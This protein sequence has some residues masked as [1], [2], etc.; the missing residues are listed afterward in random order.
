MCVCED[1]PKVL[2]PDQNSPCAQ[3]CKECIQSGLEDDFLNCEVTCDE[4]WIYEYYP[5]NEWQSIERREVDESQPKL[6]RMSKSKVKSM[7]IVFFD[8]CGI[9]VEES[10]SPGQTVNLLYY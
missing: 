3:L 1:V 2:M 10:V 5:C 9:N 6:A 7:L 4:S 8:Y